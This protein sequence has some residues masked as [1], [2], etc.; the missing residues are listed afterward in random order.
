MTY[1]SSKSQEFI[2]IWD[3]DRD[4]FVRHFDLDAM[5]QNTIIRGMK[6]DGRIVETHDRNVMHPDHRILQLRN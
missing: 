6:P 3:K 5:K 1:V 4:I 2:Y